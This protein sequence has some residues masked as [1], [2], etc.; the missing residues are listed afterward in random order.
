MAKILLI[1]DEAGIR[2]VYA[3]VLKKEGY[4]VE[5]AEDGE[6]GLEKI[7]TGG[8]SLILLDI[9]LPKM[10]GLAIL[11]ELKKKAPQEANGPIVLLTNL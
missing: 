7:K 6:A 10:D 5:T 8:Y 9:M 1:E 11:T 3:D 4:T 2:Q